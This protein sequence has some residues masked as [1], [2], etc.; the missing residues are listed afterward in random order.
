MSG[1]HQEARDCR[2]MHKLPKAR[3]FFLEKNN[4]FRSDFQANLYQ[5]GSVTTMTC[6][7]NSVISPVQAGKLL[8]TSSWERPLCTCIQLL[9]AA[10]GL[11]CIHLLG[12]STTNADPH[13]AHRCEPNRAHGES[14]IG[15]LFSPEVLWVLPGPRQASSPYFL[16]NG[17]NNALRQ[18]GCRSPR[19][20]ALPLGALDTL[21]PSREPKYALCECR[22][23]MFWAAAK[24]SWGTD[25]PR[26]KRPDDAHISL[27]WASGE[28]QLR[29]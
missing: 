17:R 1:E 16:Y 10:A 5:I 26:K 27:S 22:A 14:Q 29:G 21:G 23:S 8:C 2:F 12:G 28:G 13:A 19:A 24:V 15:H 6:N 4:S 11:N 9:M 20:L 18:S 25:G 3:T 7:P